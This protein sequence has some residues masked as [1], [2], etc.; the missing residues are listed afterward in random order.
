MNSTSLIGT[1]VTILA[2]LASIM[3]LG[4]L[5]LAA[6]LHFEDAGRWAAL[7]PAALCLVVAVGIAKLRALQTAQ[8]SFTTAFNNISHG[9]CMFV[10]VGSFC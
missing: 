10:P 5:G 6:L 8:M 7:V 2:V 4:A 1:R 3:T 9:L